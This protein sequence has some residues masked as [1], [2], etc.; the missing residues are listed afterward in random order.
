M[1]TPVNHFKEALYNGSPQIGFWLSLT[2]PNVAEICAGAGFDWLLIDAEHG[3]QTLPGIVNQLRAIEA[4]PPCAAVVRVPSRD[5]VAIR[6]I[7]DLGAQSIMIPMIGTA[8]EAADAVKAC[9]YPPAGERGIGGARASRWGRY[10][11]YVAEANS[12]LCLIAQIETSAGLKNLEDIA[13]IDGIDALFI[14]PVDLAASTGLL[15]A[16]NY[17]ALQALTLETLS[18]IVETGKPAGI[19]SRDEE[20]LAKHLENGAGF[21]AVGIDSFALAKAASQLAA[22]WKGRPPT[23]RS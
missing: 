5:P 16:E 12:Q 8:E 4:N 19:L 22:R 11:A 14:G 10:P 2:C 1:Q 13:A 23:V 9:R 6:Q 21:P 3:P 15:G 7:L 20:L 17:D 18:R